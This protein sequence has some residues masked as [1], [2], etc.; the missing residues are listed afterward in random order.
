MDQSL[1][2]PDAVSRTKDWYEQYYSQNGPLRN[3]LLR[4]PGVLFQ[5]T[6]L[7][8]SIIRALGFIAPDPNSARV[9][10][11][12]CGN[13]GGL[14]TFLRLG[15]QPALLHGMDMLEERIREARE[16]F[17]NANFSFGEASRMEYADQMFDLVIESRLFVRLPDESLCARIAAEMVR[18]TKLGGFLLLADWRYSRPGKL[19][20]VGLSKRRIKALFGVGS[21]CEVVGHF[22]GALVPPVG[23]FLSKY[24]SSLYFLVQR[25]FP[26]LVGQ[27]VTVLKRIA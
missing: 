8:V 20:Y 13:G 2:N 4:N 17:P 15:F 14:I 1:A 22:S 27:R 3:D 23:R 9:L 25:L 6:A 19:R 10:S 18:V 5:S 12:P 7:E 24:A 16:R 21:R 26:F 11:V